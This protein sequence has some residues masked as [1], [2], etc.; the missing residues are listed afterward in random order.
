[1]YTAQALSW[2]L[3]A[4]FISLTPPQIPR[5][6]K[7]SILTTEGACLIRLVS[8]HVS[9]KHHL[10]NQTR[11]AVGKKRVSR[12]KLR[13]HRFAIGPPPFLSNVGQE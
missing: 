5:Q 10:I 1:M 3:L 6:G 11:S 7:K 2:A 13:S 12:K 9:Q 4:L 8:P